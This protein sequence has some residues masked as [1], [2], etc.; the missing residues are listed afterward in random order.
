[1]SLSLTA[2]GEASFFYSGSYSY[3]LY[4]LN[5]FNNLSLLFNRLFIFNFIRICIND[6]AF[7]FLSSPYSTF[8]F[9]GS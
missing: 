5:E 4:I 6:E 8:F 9:P 7:Y 1:L 2:S 3:L